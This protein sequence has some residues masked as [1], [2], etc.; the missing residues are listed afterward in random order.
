M[1][2]CL[3]ERSVDHVLLERGEIA[4]TWRTERWESLRLLTPNWQGRLPGHVY[5]GDDPDGFMTIPE[6]VSFIPGDGKA[7]AAPVQTD[8]TVTS[9]R[10]TDG[11]Y[12]VVTDQGEWQCQTVVLATGAFN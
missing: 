6:V 4:H 1:S 9:V 8:T 11:G 12:S 2:R 7:H 5:D 10:R 3:A